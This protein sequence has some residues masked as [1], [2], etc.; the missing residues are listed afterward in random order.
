MPCGQIDYHTAFYI[1]LSKI[2]LHNRND[3]RASVSRLLNNYTHR[4]KNKEQFSLDASNCSQP[5]RSLPH[6]NRRASVSR[7][8]G[9]NS[10]SLVKTKE[11]FCSL[12]GSAQNLNAHFRTLIDGLRKA[13]RLTIIRIALK[14]E[15]QFSLDASYCSRPKRF[16]QHLNL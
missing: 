12:F 1:R 2:M 15:E 9:R 7:F 13:G 14:F 8:F 6:L 11:Q 16:S 4:A 5:K 10:Q 3:R